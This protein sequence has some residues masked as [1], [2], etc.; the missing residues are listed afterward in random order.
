MYKFKSRLF[1]TWLVHFFLKVDTGSECNLLPIKLYKSLT[2]DMNL[3]MLCMY[4]EKNRVFIISLL[5]QSHGRSN[6][7]SIFAWME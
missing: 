6:E 4:L 3:C 5:D 7:P 2:G 1:L